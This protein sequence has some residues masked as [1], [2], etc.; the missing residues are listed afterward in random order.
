MT[1][2]MSAEH[3]LRMR[4]EGLS[5]ALQRLTD[6]EAARALAAEV[7]ERE[8]ATAALEYVLSVPVGGPECGCG[9]DHW[10][11]DYDQDDGTDEEDPGAEDPDLDTASSASRQHWIDTGRYLRKGE[12][13]ET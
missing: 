2:Q 9:G 6:R 7:L 1:G 4:I 11:C 5:R 12:A 10:S 13:L 8:D 3:E